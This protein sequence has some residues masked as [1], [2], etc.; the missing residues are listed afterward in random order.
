[1]YYNFIDSD[2]HKT[3]ALD[4]TFSDHSVDS[5]LSTTSIAGVQC[6]K[7]TASDSIQ[8]EIH[9]TKRYRVS[10]SMPN[11]TNPELISDTDILT[12]SLPSLLTDHMNTPHISPLPISSN[13]QCTNNSISTAA[14]TDD[15]S[16][17]VNITISSLLNEVPVNSSIISTVSLTSTANEVPINVNVSTVP[18]PSPLNEVPVD[19]YPTTV[20]LPS[21]NNATTLSLDFMPSPLTNGTSN[22]TTLSI[23]PFLTE[24]PT[25][26]NCT[27][28]SLEPLPSLLNKLPTD[29]VTPSSSI[30]DILSLPPLPIPMSAGTLS[31]TSVSINDEIPFRDMVFTKLPATVDVPLSLDETKPAHVD[32]NLNYMHSQTVTSSLIS[33]PVLFSSAIVTACCDSTIPILATDTIMSYQS[34]LG[35]NP[36]SSAKSDSLI[37][38]TAHQPTIATIPT[39]AE[40]TVSTQSKLISVNDDS[41]AIFASTTPLVPTSDISNVD[42]NVLLEA[43]TTELGVDSID[44]S[45]LNMSDLLSLL[46]PEDSLNQLALTTD[47]GTSE[48]IVLQHSDEL[49]IEHG[50]NLNLNEDELLQDLPPEL[51]ETVQAI[52]DSQKEMEID[53]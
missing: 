23:D 37:L 5:I 47:Q 28:L 12:Q 46:Q 7:R 2:K 40:L 44:P 9:S 17:K 20:S 39:I 49:G 30:S 41:K 25:N 11:L 33:Q 4:H 52:L 42:E 16:A 24:I 32:S 38:C 45:L 14:T 48:M 31:L 6:R 8:E 27:T 19:S 21:L 13:V 43:V 53:F 26:S 29:N 10:S 35:Y 18:L 50:V 51:R 15:V 22:T 1:M 36:L 3:T 34:A